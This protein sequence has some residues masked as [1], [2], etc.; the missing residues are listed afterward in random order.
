VLRQN[1]FTYEQIEAIVRDY[2][3]AGLDPVDVAVMA[4]AEKIIREPHGTATAD[5]DALRDLGLTDTEILDIALVA[6]ARAF[7][8]KVIDS[9]GVEPDPTRFAD[10]PPTLLEAVTV[11]RPFPSSS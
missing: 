9:M 1:G 2:R 6:G 5:A 7:F 10:F 11:G 4:F 8:S 3:N